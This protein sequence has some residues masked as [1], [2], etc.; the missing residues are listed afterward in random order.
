MTSLCSVQACEAGV[1]VVDGVVVVVVGVVGVVVV[2]V[3]VVV[4]ASVV[5][6]VKRSQM[7]VFPTQP[8]ASGSNFSPDAKVS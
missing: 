8:S 7:G 5:V 1:V 3:V 6:G 2:V 4:G